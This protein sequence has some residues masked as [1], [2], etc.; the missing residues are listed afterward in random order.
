MLALPCDVFRPESQRSIHRQA[1][2]VL[3]EQR[4]RAGRAGQQCRTTQKETPGRRDGRGGIP[5][6][7]EIAALSA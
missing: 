2:D 4:N 6:E 5:F 7:G 3:R 1:S